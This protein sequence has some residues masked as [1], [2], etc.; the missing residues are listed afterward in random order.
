MMKGC[1]VSKNGRTDSSTETPKSKTK[2]IK[3]KIFRNLENV[4][5]LIPSECR[6]KKEEASTQKKFVMISL[7][8]ALSISLA[9]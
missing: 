3:I 5:R 6:L 2:M 1:D 7:V 9:G 4:Q 8:L